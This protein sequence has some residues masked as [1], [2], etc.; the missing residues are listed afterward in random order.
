[1]GGLSFLQGTLTKERT[2]SKLLSEI[3][4]IPMGDPALH[5]CVISV[6]GPYL[7]ML[8]IQRDMARTL[9]PI[10]HYRGEDMNV[11]FKDIILSGLR[12][13]AEKYRNG[14]L[15]SAMELSEESPA[16][17]DGEAVLPEKG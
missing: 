3:T 11:Y 14:E 10:F 4:G 16:G 8:C 9:A 15:P 12:S 6:M 2:I 5:C 13:F 1:L 7:I 17:K